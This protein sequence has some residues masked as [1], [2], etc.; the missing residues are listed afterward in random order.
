MG[1][2]SPKGIT[3]LKTTISM[4]LKKKDSKKFLDLGDLFKHLACSHPVGSVAALIPDFSAFCFP[5]ENHRP[6][7]ADLCIECMHILATRR[8]EEVKG[9][10]TS[11][12]GTRSDE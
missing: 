4:S 3:H 8:F 6:R 5:L 7:V 9:F 12:G 11:F 1:F 2:S 10:Q